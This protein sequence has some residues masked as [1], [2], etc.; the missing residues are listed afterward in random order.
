MR[1][2]RALVSLLALALFTLVGSA[3]TYTVRWGD[4]LGGIAHRA[5]LPVGLLASANR[6]S[7][8]NRLREGQ[9]L[10]VPTPARP[11]TASPPSVTIHTVGRGETLGAIARRYHTSVAHLAQLNG[12]RDVNR[13]R[14][15]FDLRLDAP[16]ATWVCPVQHT[17]VFGSRFGD[18]RGGGRRHQGVDLVAPRGSVVVAN[19]AGVLEHH[20]N[21]LGGIAYYLTGDDGSRYYGAHLESF[22]GGEGRVRLGQAIGRVGNTGDA[23]GGVTHLHFERMPGGGPSVDPMPL[24]ARACPT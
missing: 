9:V 18:P 15:G 21:R 20:P 11:A 6:L 17:V 23:V 16:A 10:T 3:G 24:L 2:P 8:P 12:I 1:T 7:D 4:T 5:G 13:L 22:I 14:E 19:V